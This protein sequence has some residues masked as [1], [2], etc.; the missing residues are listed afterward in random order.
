MHAPLLFLITSFAASAVAAPVPIASIRPV[1]PDSPVSAV[2]QLLTRET[3][4]FPVLDS[5][6]RAL[7]EGLDTVI[8]TKR[9]ASP[10]DPNE[11]CD[12]GPSA[13]LPDRKAKR[14]T[15][16]RTVDKREALTIATRY[17]E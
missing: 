2:E 1:S 5:I 14:C 10:E 16:E 6:K 8:G 7:L 11:D 4:D 17:E 12:R 9:A 15:H 3:A 13:D